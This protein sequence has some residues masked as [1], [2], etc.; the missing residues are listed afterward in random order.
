MSKI[1]SRYTIALLEVAIEEERV[2]FYRDQIK[3]IQDTIDECPGL[4]VFLNHYLISKEDKKALIKK[5]FAD[6]DN[7]SIIKFLYVIIDHD[8]CSNL[9]TIIDD[10]LKQSNGYMGI[11]TGYVY[12]AYQ[13]DEKQLKEIE[14]AISIKLDKTVWLENIIDQK[15]ISGVKI[16]VD[17]NVID[18]SLKNKISLLRNS[19][20]S[21]GG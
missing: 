13:L 15:L 18:G 11:L 14:E 4:M 8:R 16:V 12:S 17:D 3:L 21:R 19:L 1:A 10:F 9:V 2:S 7:E 6:Q 20:L 5:I